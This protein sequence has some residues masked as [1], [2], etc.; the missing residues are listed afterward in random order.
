MSDKARDTL[1]IRCP[2]CSQKLDVTGVPGFTEVTCPNCKGVLTVPQPFGPFLLE[3]LIGE[4]RVAKVYRALDT[5]LDR[6]VA[7]KVIRDG[8]RDTPGA[9]DTFLRQAKKIAAVTHPRILPIY[10]CGEWE[11][12]ACLVMQYM[13]KLSLAFRLQQ[14]K[15]GLPVEA[16]VRTFLAAVQGLDAAA[17]GGIVHHNLCPANILVDAEGEVKVGDFGLSLAGWC[18]GR[19]LRENLR[20]SLATLAYTSPERGLTG[21]QD[22]RGDIYALGACLYHVLTGRPTAFGENTDEAFQHRLTEL[23]VAPRLLR[24]EIPEPLDGLV[25]AMLAGRPDERP[26]SWA[27]VAAGL[28]AALRP[29][30]P[31]ARK[32]GAAVTGG[33]RPGIPIP[34]APG[35][36]RSRSPARPAVPSRPATRGVG[37]GTAILLVLLL[38]AGLLAVAAHRQ[39]PWYVKYLK[40]SVDQATGWMRRLRFRPLSGAPVRPAPAAPRA[41]AGVVSSPGPAASPAPAAAVPPASAGVGTATAPVVA[42]AGAEGGRAAA[43]SV[44]VALPAQA[45]PDAGTAADTAGAAPAAFPAD[46]PAAVPV[47]AVAADD[48]GEAAMAE[49]PSAPAEGGAAVDE[50]LMPPEPVA[51]SPAVTPAASAAASQGEKAP[52]A[53]AA[54]RPRPPDL[55]FF[56][57]RT[58]LEE[59]LRKV[60]VDERQVEAERIREISTLRPSLLR[61]LKFPYDGS[62]RGVLLRSGRRLSGTVMGND[63]ELVVRPKSGRFHQLKWSDLAFEQY[64]A[65]IEFYVEVRLERSNPEETAAAAAAVEKVV[66]APVEGAGPTR[67][68]AAAYDL[69]RLALLCDWYARPVPSLTYARK[70]VELDPSLEARLSR[71]LPVFTAAG[72]AR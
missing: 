11:G 39:P 38:L 22:L 17:R 70:A 29:A 40:P 32:A 55:D 33:P 21:E 6:E 26:Q 4:G 10:S 37:L 52:P 8:V 65:F 13:A 56:K 45:V 57:V 47:P 15:T 1:K 31:G 34:A 48:G 50:T 16:S 61:Y 44:P 24:K 54:Q 28:E 14:A 43:P 41:G 25:L 30:R 35:G 2:L 49:P 5:T 18:E 19:S 66:G 58:A 59:H 46:G 62:K 64:L 12:R 20:N 53:Y 9:A 71:L 3:E 69:F 7:V 67:E 60:P 72:A 51:V 27:E 23:P 36:G 63:H 42:P 68:Q